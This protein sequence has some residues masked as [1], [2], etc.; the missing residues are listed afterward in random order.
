MV[1]HAYVELCFVIIPL[2]LPFLTLPVP[3]FAGPSSSIMIS[4]FFAIK[5]N[6]IL[7]VFHVFFFQASVDYLS[8]FNFACIVNGVAVKWMCKCLCGVA[9][10]P[11]RPVFSA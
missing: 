11:T 6:S 1:I 10:S 4:F 3:C 7:C 8:L 2:S 5:N 9:P